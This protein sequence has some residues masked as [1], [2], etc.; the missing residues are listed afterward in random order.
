MEDD[1]LTN[2]LSYVLL[3][4]SF[5]I[6]LFMLDRIFGVRYEPDD[7]KRKRPKLETEATSAGYSNKEEATESAVELDSLEPAKEEEPVES[8][9]SG[10]A[11]H[12]AFF[13]TLES[14]S[15]RYSAGVLAWSC[16]KRY[17]HPI[18]PV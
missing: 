1:K 8:E 11:D 16:Q 18:L 13:E 12:E 2:A 14:P 5:F 6:V 17:E 7:L 10:A 15:L 9:S 3:L 4:A